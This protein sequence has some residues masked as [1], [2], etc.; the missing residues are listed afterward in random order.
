MT[1]RALTHHPVTFQNCSEAAVRAAASFAREPGQAVTEIAAQLEGLDLGFILFFCAPGYPL[2]QLADALNST[3]PAV[4]MAGCTSAGEISSEGYSQGSLTALGFSRD[5]FHVQG[6]LVTE[7]SAGS[8]E[9]VPARVTRLLTQYDI[10]RPGQRFAL[11]LIDGLSML[12]EQT[13]ATF[14]LALGSIPQFGAS[15]A[16]PDGE[17]QQT[18]VFL[19]GE[20]HSDAAV[21]LLFHS[22]FE[23][24]VFSRHHL[25][26]RRR[27][28]VVTAACDSGR[29][30]LE[31]DAMPAA[32]AYAEMLGLPVEALNEE[33][34]AL[35]PL[36]VRLGDQYYVRAIQRCNP[37]HS[38]TFYAAIDTGVILTRMQRPDICRS[39][40]TWLQQIEQE[41]GPP[42]LVIGCDCLLRR[43]EARALGREAELSA[44]LR[45]F[46]VIGF[47]TYGE[48][49][50]GMVFNQTF[51]GVAIGQNRHE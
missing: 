5:S 31:L 15:A 43:V 13:L 37:D 28:L 32:L 12:E 40:T 17:S 49:Y 34:F 2:S 26:P 4:P 30:V 24:K 35:N 39:L 46:R 51:T 6:C 16:C 45:R 20:F 8:L 33:V 9:G 48:H 10:T 41:I 7:L 50:S 42:Q 1:T 21:L 3:L 25:A 14:N 44:L 36:A 27:K 19:D 22:R 23:F 29:R 38:L 47:N 18:W 11:T